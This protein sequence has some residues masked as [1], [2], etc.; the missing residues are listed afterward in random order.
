MK[1]VKSVDDYIASVE[2]WGEALEKLRS[3]LLDTE[4]EET[5]KWG[6]PVYAFDGKNVAGIGAF[7]SYFGL[8]FFQGA[9][10]K[11][12][13]NKLVNAQEGKTQALRQWRINSIE[14]IDEKLIKQYVT[15][16]IQNQ[17]EGRQIKPAKNKPLDIPAELA[18]AFEKNKLLKKAFDQFSLSKQREFTE[19]I[20]EA[21]RE[22]TRLARL[23][24]SIPMILEGIG[25]NDK[26]RG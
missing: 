6:G 23:E 3:I 24:K 8:W 18:Q 13:Q 19:Y 10:L 22:A 1:K 11:D 2:G 17:K 7:K 5:V 14:E 4:L 9:L 12:Y 21:K 20:G 26:Y 15:E 25:M 16:A